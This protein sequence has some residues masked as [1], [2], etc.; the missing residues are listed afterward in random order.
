MV[1]SISEAVKAIV[2][3]YERV[4][5]PGRPCEGYEVRQMEK[6]LEVLS[7]EL[8]KATEAKFGTDVK[9][10]DDNMNINKLK[11]KIV[12]NGM[13]V[14]RLADMMGVDRATLYRKLNNSE[15]I[16][17]GEALT[18]KKILG[19]SNAEAFEIFLA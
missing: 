4:L 19:M 12:E 16:T 10:G 2:N 11:G 7:E 9:G 17:I 13:N 3:N 14:E 5:T 6:A 18:M 15:K 8:A 1:M